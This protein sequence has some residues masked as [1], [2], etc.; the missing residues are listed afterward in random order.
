MT[1][2]PPQLII[3]GS[4]ESLTAA[5]DGNDPCRY[6][7]PRDTYKQT[8]PKDLIQGQANLQTCTPASSVT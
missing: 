1:Y 7:D 2:T 3:H 4:V 6:N 5:G 8:G